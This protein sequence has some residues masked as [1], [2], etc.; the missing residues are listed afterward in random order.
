MADFTPAALK[1]R[2]L[3]LDLLRRQADAGSGPV[4][5]AE[6]EFLLLLEF[7]RN[8][9]R[10]IPKKELLSDIWGYRFDTDSNVVD[11]YLRRLRAKL[12]DQVIRTVRGEGYRVDA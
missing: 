10:S 1:V 3:S 11:V 9:G 5:L 12:G 7:M 6:R 4:S 8:A 2:N